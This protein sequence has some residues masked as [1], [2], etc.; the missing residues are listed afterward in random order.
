MNFATRLTGADVFLIVV[1]GFMDADEA[2]IGIDARTVRM[3]D[4][5]GIDVLAENV[6]DRNLGGVLDALGEYTSVWPIL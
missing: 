5:G 1:H 3:Q 4:A 2:N 6:L